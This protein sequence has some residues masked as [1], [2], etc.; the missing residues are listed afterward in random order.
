M[1]STLATV[2]LAV[3]MGIYASVAGALGGLVVA[4]VTLVTLVQMR[5]AR[6]ERTSQ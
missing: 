4:A 2:E 3:W 6:A 1:A 5:V